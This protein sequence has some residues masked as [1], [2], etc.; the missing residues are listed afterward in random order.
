MIK[1]A[2]VSVSSSREKADDTSGKKVIEILKGAGFDIVS[3]KIIKDDMERIK[4]KLVECIGEG[5]EV[6]FTTGGTGL[7]PYDFTPEA[8][9]SV[10]EREIPGISQ[11]MR[12]EGFKM[13]ERAAL[14]R[15]ISAQKGRTLIINLPGSPEGAIES[16]SAVIGIIPH[17]VDMI[18]GKGH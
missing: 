2:V 4:E 15:G 7:G 14:S 1:T 11:L 17:A 6:I 13:T 10:A 3:Y 16:L 9:A 12:L 8:T 18:K 5:V